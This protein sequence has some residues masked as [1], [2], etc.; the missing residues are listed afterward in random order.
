MSIALWVIQSLLAL[1]FL[2][3]GVPKA[4]RPLP[5]LANV[6]PWTSGAAAAL[7]RF[8]GVVEILGALGLIL[9]GFTHIATFLIP[10]AAA[11]L[12][13]VMLL[14]SG[15]HVRRGEYQN[16]APNVILLALALLIAI[17]RFTA[18]PLA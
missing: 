6:M 3:A 1:A 9:P 5:S 13:L 4:F 15:F 7:V 2:L 14:A 17:G 10:L 8:I 16:L 11:G 12:A 18:W